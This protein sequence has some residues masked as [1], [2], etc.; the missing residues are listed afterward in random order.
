MEPVEVNAIQEG[1]ARIA[2]AMLIPPNRKLWD[3]TAV[4]DYFGLSSSATYRPI[5]CKPDFPLPIKIVGGCK[6]WVAGEVM[7]WAE[8]KREKRGRNRTDDPE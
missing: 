5:L 7:A 8:T 3:A 6:R 1:F 4:A 2:N